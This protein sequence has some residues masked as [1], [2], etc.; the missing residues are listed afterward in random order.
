MIK[1]P[2]AYD[3]PFEAGSRGL[4][5]ADTKPV[6][7]ETVNALGKELSILCSTLAIRTWERDVL[8]AKSISLKAE[9]DATEDEVN[10]LQNQSS[11]AHESAQSVEQRLNRAR[12]RS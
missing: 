6:T 1:F 7:P 11:V 2:V 12:L 8:M 9:L 3:P 10:R 4:M 5:D